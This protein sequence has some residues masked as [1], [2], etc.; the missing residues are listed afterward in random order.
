MTEIN[1]KRDDLFTSTLKYMS[2]VLDNLSKVVSKGLAG[3]SNEQKEALDILQ[4]MLKWHKGYLKSLQGVRYSDLSDK[5]IIK[6]I[7]DLL[8]AP[9]SN[10]DMG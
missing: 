7:K 9:D 3:D 1:F 4:S 5:D 10:I 8:A 2:D 6:L